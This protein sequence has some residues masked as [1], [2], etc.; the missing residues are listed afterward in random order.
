MAITLT[1]ADNVLKNYYLDAV[2]EQ[3]DYK[4]N[5]FFA[6]INKT[7][8]YVFGKEIKKLATYGVNGGIGAGTEDGSLP[9]ATGNNYAQMTL[10]LKNLYGTIEISDKAIKASENSAGAFANLLT[11]EMEGLVKSG[12][13]NLGRML[14]GD[15]SGVL[16]KVV[17]ITDGVI[18]FDAVEN[19]V[20]GM[21]IEF[22]TPLGALIDSAK[23][24]RVIAVDRDEKTVTVSGDVLSGST[25]AAN[26]FATIQ[27]SY[28]NE[29][30]GLGAIFGGAESLYGL[31]RTLNSWLSPLVKGSIGSPTGAKL[32]KMIDEIEERSGSKVNLMLCSYG[33]RRSLYST[34]GNTQS[35]NI[36]P[37]VN[38]GFTSITYN[39]I[40]IVAD[41]FCPKGYIYFL[42]TDDFELHQLCDWQWLSGDDGSVLKQV[43]G[44]PVYSATLVK[45]ADLICSKPF[46]QGL[47][48]GVTEAS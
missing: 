41:R 12:A 36:G 6:K 15:G 5:P 10:S 31:P 16:G 9:S 13:I 11:A 25:I 3:L 48:T 34:I 24:R 8:N 39:G 29:L 1:N 14:F 4:A 30:T 35:A 18:T 42:N 26:S 22:R 20:E 44:K 46:G 40:P 32:L 7:S 23:G 37:E 47:M 43:A 45:Y 19:F 27:G 28:G 2:A 33:V 38:G 21:V 17:S